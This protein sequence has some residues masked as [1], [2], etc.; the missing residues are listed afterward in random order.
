MPLPYT[1][2]HYHYCDSHLFL[3][4]QIREKFILSLNGE[5]EKFTAAVKSLIELHRIIEKFNTTDNQLELVQELTTAV[6][7]D[8]CKWVRTT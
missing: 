4:P 7:E 8:S 6:A 1:L 3:N 5:T 2:H